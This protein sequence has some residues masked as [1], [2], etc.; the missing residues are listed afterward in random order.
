MRGSSQNADPVYKKGEWYFEKEFA[1]G[2][3]RRLFA[4]ASRG[5][6]GK[7]EIGEETFNPQVSREVPRRRRRRE[8]SEEGGPSLRT[9]WRR[10]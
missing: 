6:G 8:E 5:V 10:P 2:G 9:V 7:G 3:L 4:L 1:R